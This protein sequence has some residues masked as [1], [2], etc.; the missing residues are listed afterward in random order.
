MLGLVV[1]SDK[2]I[3]F[4]FP[5]GLAVTI[6]TALLNWSLTGDL[7]GRRSYAT[8]RGILGT[9]YG[10]ATFLSPVY[11]GWIFDR[12]GSYTIVLITFSIILLVSTFILVMLC[13]TSL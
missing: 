2:T 1:S 12:T 9:G 13:F 3:L 6:G 11:A 4:A 8:L 5:I 10:E 7:F